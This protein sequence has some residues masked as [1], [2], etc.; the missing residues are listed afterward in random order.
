MYTIAEKQLL[1]LFEI[2]AAKS[3]EKEDASPILT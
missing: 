2:S 1:L 3:G